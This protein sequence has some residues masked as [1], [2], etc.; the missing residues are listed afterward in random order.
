MQVVAF[1]CVAGR[2]IVR[3][4]IR[5]DTAGLGDVFNVMALVS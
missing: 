2:L 5:K 3:L 1:V 4:R